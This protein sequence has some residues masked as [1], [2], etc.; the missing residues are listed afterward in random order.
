MF[1]VFEVK[2]KCVSFSNLVSTSFYCDSYV[3]L[4][5]QKIGATWPLELSEL[6]RLVPLAKD[7]AF[8]TV[9]M[10]VKQVRIKEIPHYFG[11]RQTQIT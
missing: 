8:Q 1:T 11:T 9:V 10:R 4:I 7:K 5:S 6:K 2:Y 3:H